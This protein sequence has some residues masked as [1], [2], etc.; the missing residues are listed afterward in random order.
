[1]VVNDLPSF[2]RNS[3]VLSAADKAA[4]AH[5]ESIPTEIEVDG[6]RGLPEILE[7]TNA[8]IG[9]E[10]SRDT[11]LQLKAKEYL[12]RGDLVM[13]WKTLLL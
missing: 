8:F 4:L 13:A 11:H 1:M 7:L 9:D 10:S 12:D 5:I 2:V 6:I 3:V